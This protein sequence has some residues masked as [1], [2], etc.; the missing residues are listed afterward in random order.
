LS[1]KRKA[2]SEDIEVLIT[3][4]EKWRGNQQ[5]MIQR[6]IQHWGFDNPM[7]HPL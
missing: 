7:V 5:W 1:T 3:V 6:H 4:T 2:Q